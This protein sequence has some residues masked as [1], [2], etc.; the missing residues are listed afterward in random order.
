MWSI[1]FEKNYTSTYISLPLTIKSL[2]IW[3][4]N[5]DGDLNELIN[6]ASFLARLIDSTEAAL[7]DVNAPGKWSKPSAKSEKA[8]NISFFFHVSKS[9]TPPSK[10]KTMVYAPSM[11]SSTSSALIPEASTIP[12]KTPSKI[13]SVTCK[14]R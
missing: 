7:H 13:S 3:K 2:A 5:D 8:Y 10:S 9:L 4:A 11:H 6:D 14:S 12:S 1:L